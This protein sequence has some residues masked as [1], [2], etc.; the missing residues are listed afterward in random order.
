VA[1]RRQEDDERLELI[2]AIR[3]AIG[4]SALILVNANDRT[5]P[6]TASYI[7]GYFMECTRTRSAADWKRI[8]GTLAWGGEHLRAPRVMCLETW[9]HQ[10]RQDLSLMRATTTMSLVLGD[11]Y[12]LFS[13]PNPLARAGPPARL[14]SLLGQVARQGCRKGCRARGWRLV[15]RVRKRY[16]DLQSV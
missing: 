5:T 11:G 2:R 7:N 3:V 12:A 9:Y 15:A 13:D 6:R 10:S 16:S 8:A 1:G 4:D 14:V